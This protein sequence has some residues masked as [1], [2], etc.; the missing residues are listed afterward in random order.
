MLI[1]NWKLTLA[2][3][4][5]LNEV[6]TLPHGTSR[7]YSAV[8]FF[9]GFKACD[10]MLKNNNPPAIEKAKSPFPGKIKVIFNDRKRTF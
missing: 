6:G 1:W 4:F 5:E 8:I 2:R 3:N 10:S 7:I 9:A